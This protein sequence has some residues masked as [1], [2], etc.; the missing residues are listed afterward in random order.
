MFWGFGLVRNGAFVSF[1]LLLNFMCIVYIF[2]LCP[3]VVRFYVLLHEWIKSKNPDDLWNA[4]CFLS[5][6]QPIFTCFFPLF[7]TWLWLKPPQNEFRNPIVQI[8]NNFSHHF[9][10][11]AMNPNNYLWTLL[12]NCSHKANI[13][14]VSETTDRYTTQW[15]DSS[16]DLLMNRK[17]THIH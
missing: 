16:L 2:F 17:H 5:G 9:Q 10:T 13:T 1:S 12:V 7:C 6:M 3:V 4:Q 14:N 15:M 8:T 11:I